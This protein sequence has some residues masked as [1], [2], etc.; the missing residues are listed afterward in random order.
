MM[1]DL[2]GALSLLQ[3]VEDGEGRE[4]QR[5]LFEQLVAQGILTEED[6]IFWETITLHR[7][8]RMLEALR[9]RT[10]YITVVLEAVDDGH[11]QA[12]V[13]RSADAFGVQEVSIIRGRAPFSPNQ[14]VTQG[15]HKWLTLHRFPD[16]EATVQSLREQGYRIWASQPDPSAVP[17]DQV[18][19]SQPAAFLF[20]NEHDGLSD[21]ALDLAD[22]TFVI[23]MVGFVQSL[24]ISVAAA[25][26][27]IQ[28]THRARQLAGARYF[29]TQ[30]EQ[31]AVLRHWLRIA[32]SRTRRI[33]RMLENR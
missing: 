9:Q 6:R 28:A 8:R 15:A 12:A 29:L 30:E 23:P 26:T 31:R 16:I 11:N 5:A 2:D 25:I 3:N 10:R 17:I 21:R 18:D 27:L 4:E 33:A 7:A 20:G 1:H 22:G 32:T 19:L 13:L 24:N 14:G